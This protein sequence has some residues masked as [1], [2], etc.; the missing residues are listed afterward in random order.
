MISAM[1][2]ESQEAAAKKAVELGAPILVKKLSPKKQAGKKQAAEAA[3]PSK[4]E[5]DIRAELERLSAKRSR[6]SATSARAGSKATTSRRPRP[7]KPIPSN[8]TKKPSP[9]TPRTSR[10]PRT[11]SNLR[12]R[13]RP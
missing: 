12:R 3:R 8:R 10:T 11:G 6:P 7:K 2:L 13:W 9:T 1:D 4:I 5:E